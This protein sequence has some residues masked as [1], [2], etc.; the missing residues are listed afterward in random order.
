LL[1]LSS[2][3]EQL[4]DSRRHPLLRRHQPVEQRLLV[5]IDTVYAGHLVVQ[6]QAC[7][8]LID[9]YALGDRAVRVPQDWPVSHGSDFSFQTSVAA[10]R[11][12]IAGR[13]S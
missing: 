13:F 1:R 5:D 10:A 8:D 4:G 9:A 2:S 7:V 3:V 11:G 6:E 12:D